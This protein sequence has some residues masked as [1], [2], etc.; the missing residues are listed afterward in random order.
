MKV[1]IIGAGITGCFTAARLMHKGVDISVLAR[2]DKA[3]RLER[4]GLRMRDGI[5]GE[6]ATVRLHVV[7][8]PA[9]ETFDV[10][11]R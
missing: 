2:G 11:R 9:E 5:T 4:D 6:T 1:L 3:A 8:W 7:R 10:V